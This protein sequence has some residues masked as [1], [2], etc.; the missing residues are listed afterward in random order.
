MIIISFPLP[1]ASHALGPWDAF[2]RSVGAQSLRG[3]LAKN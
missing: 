1:T 3:G 2:L